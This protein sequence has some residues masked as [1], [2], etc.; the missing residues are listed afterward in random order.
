[1]LAKHHCAPNY[2]QSLSFLSRCNRSAE[3]RKQFQELPQNGTNGILIRCLPGVREQRHAPLAVPRFIRSPQTQKVMPGTVAALHCSAIGQPMP[4]IVWMRNGAYMH[5]TSQSIGGQSTLRV[6]VDDNDDVGDYICLAQNVAGVA[7]TVGT[8][9][10]ERKPNK[11]E[12]RSV[13]MLDCISTDKKQLFVG[14]IVWKLFDS[15]LNS[16][17]ESVKRLQNGSLIV[18]DVNRNNSVKML[19]ALLRIDRLN[20]LN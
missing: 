14:N 13:A 7:S 19:C 12:R 11:T 6:K 1:M 9:V 15:V 18:F 3:F 17:A 10:L 16:S 20:L 5:S 2:S 8:L 4:Q